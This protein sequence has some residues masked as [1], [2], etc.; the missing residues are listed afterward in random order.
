MSLKP[1]ARSSHRILKL[2]DDVYLNPSRL[3]A[4]SAQWG[5]M[6]AQYLGCMK[7]GYPLRTPGTKWYEPAHLLVGA[8]YWL[9]TYGSIYAISGPVARSGLCKVLSSGPTTGFHSVCCLPC[10]HH[11]G[12]VPD[13]A[14]LH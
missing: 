1:A 7:H 11:V 13:L 5:R 14:T 9:H 4:A 12:V 6:G 2:D 3:L 10:L 8:N